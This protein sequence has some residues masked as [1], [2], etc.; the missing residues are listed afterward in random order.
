VIYRTRFGKELDIS[1]WPKG[2]RT[3][4]RKVYIWYLR[5]ITYTDFVSMIFGV[6]SPVLK[7]SSNGPEPTKTPLYETVTDLQFRL[8]VKQGHFSKDWEG[9][10]EPVWPTKE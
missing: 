9:D 5:D 4:L 6:T 10:V 3:F 8:G 1:T 7:V 2:H